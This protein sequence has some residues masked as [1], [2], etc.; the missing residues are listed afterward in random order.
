MPNFGAITKFNTRLV[1][2]T[3]T[4]GLWIADEDATVL[5]RSNLLGADGTFATLPLDYKF[6][7]LTTTDGLRAARAQEQEDIS[8]WQLRE[9]VRSELTTDTETVQVDFM[10]TSKTTIELYTGADLSNVTYVN[11]AFEIPKPE[12]PPSR[13]YR[14]LRVAIDL[15]DGEEYYFI[16]F[17]PRMKVTN[18][19]DQADTREGALQWGVTLTAYNDG[20]VGYSKNHMQG[21]PGF[22]LVAE[23][24]GLPAVTVAP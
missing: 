4:G 10:E 8:S 3:L 2:K 20:D 5:T 7:G 6:S 12:L 11:G 21:G 24:M 13:Y 1:R 15:V 16:N 19:A 17:Y 23:D 18:F 9:P 14:V 22:A